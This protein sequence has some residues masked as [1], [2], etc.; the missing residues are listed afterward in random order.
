MKAR[1]VVVSGFRSGLPASESFPACSPACAEVE[2]ERLT[3]GG[4]EANRPDP[5]GGLRAF[6]K[7]ARV[8]VTPWSVAGPCAACGT[9]V[10]APPPRYQ[11]DLWSRIKDRVDV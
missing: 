1:T 8:R 4:H 7:G 2:A 10:P 9:P 11:P 6:R 5:R 3:A